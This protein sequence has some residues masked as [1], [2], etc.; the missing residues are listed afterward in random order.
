MP[1]L[2]SGFCM[3][4]C[5]LLVGVSWCEARGMSIPA[6]HC[7]MLRQTF[8]TVTVMVLPSLFLTLRFCEVTS[9]PICRAHAHSKEKDMQHSAKSSWSLVA[10]VRDKVPLVQSPH[11]F[12]CN[13]RKRMLIR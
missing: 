7:A 2:N 13:V 11:V 10:V 1:S 6:S 12:S 9:A 4:S 3:V 5:I 8:Q